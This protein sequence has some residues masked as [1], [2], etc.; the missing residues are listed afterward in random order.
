M[1]PSLLLLPATELRPNFLLNAD[2]SPLTEPAGP[3]GI[4]QSMSNRERY[5]NKS[6]PFCPGTEQKIKFSHYCSLFV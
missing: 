3:A 2:I 5:E 1:S 6:M 4:S